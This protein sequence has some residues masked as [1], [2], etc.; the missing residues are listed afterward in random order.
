MLAVLEKGENV[1]TK[2]Q[3]RLEANRLKAAKAGGGAGSLRQ[4]LAFGDEEV[5]SAMQGPAGERTF[6]TFL[7]RNS[8][9]LKQLLR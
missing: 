1:Q 9:L 8:T 3:Q 6:V 5:A 2:E 7:R 4:V